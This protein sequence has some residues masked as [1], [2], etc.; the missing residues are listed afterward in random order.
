MKLY[1]IRDLTQFG[2][3]ERELYRWVKNRW[4]KP[5]TYSGS[6]PKYRYQDFYKACELNMEDV[7][8]QK[9]IISNVPI[10]QNGTSMKDEVLARIKEKYLKPQ[11]LTAANKS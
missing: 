7:R 4:L 10:K 1:T 11:K 9:E 6:L 2:I 5:F 8:K 3:N